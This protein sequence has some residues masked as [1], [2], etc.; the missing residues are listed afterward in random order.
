M[1]PDRRRVFSVAGDGEFVMP[2]SVGGRDRN[3]DVVILPDVDA[4]AG[5]AVVGIPHIRFKEQGFPVAADTEFGGKVIRAAPDRS[6]RVEHQFPNPGGAVQRD[7]SGNLVADRQ[8]DAA[9]GQDR[10]IEQ[11]FALQGAE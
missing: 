1:A 5:N 6:V 11:R 2:V 3:L 8:R 7:P 4:F 9:G 10:S